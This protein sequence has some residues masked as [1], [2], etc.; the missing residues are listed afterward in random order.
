MTATANPSAFEAWNG[1][2]GLRWVATADQ[3][4][5]VLA[6][7]ADALL[8]T[9]HMR[10]GD[11]V[12]DIGCGC[13]ATTLLA[14]SAVGDAGTVVGVDISAPMLGLAR[15]RANE[16]GVIN[17][18]FVHADAQTHILEPASADLV[19]SRFGTMFF[20]DPAAAFTNIATALRPRG[21]LCLATW[22]PLVA[23][24]WL[25][26]PGAVLLNHTDLPADTADEPGMFA[27]SDPDRVTATLESA[28]FTD[29]DLAPT[30]VTFTLGE[31]VDEAVDYLA[32]S[33]PGRALLETILEGAARDAAITDVRDMLVAHRD[34]SGVRLGGATWIITATRPG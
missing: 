24:E 22:Q 19:I 15:Q 6:P 31:T 18:E 34:A 7:A 33:G 11:R 2:S 13:G 9:A 29:I 25:I 16:A 10:T 27:Q 21:R 28:G 23:N 1:D 17:A 32:D 3:R 5:R 26:A 30:E 12:L 14:A 20:S 4:D 8:A